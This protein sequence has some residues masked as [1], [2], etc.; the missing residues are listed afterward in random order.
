MRN[1]LSAASALQGA[2]GLQNL[3]H[4]TFI[5]RAEAPRL[6]DNARAPDDWACSLPD[7]SAIPDDAVSLSEL[8]TSELN[9]LQLSHCDI[10]YVRLTNTGDT[11]I[12]VTPLYIDSQAGIHRLPF[13]GTSA[14][15]RIEPGEQPRIVWAGLRTFDWT[16]GYPAS[17]G[18][19]RLVLLAVEREP[20][21]A[22]PMDFGF[23]TQTSLS[24]SGDGTVS[25]AQRSPLGQL[26]SQ[27]AFGGSATRS[28]RSRP[29]LDAQAG[30]VLFQWRLIPPGGEEG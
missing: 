13:L 30:T 3:E 9:A 26:M 29:A 19:E 20:G 8:G 23:L 21:A 18:L 15:T 24:R 4:E 10:V 5:W 17:A 2:N 14:T 25:D 28:A 12:D 27:A 7:A 16:T 22:I 6:P 11:P 1:I